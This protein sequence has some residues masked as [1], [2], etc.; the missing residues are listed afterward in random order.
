MRVRWQPVDG[1][2]GYIVLYRSI[3]GTE[4]QLD[5]EVRVRADVSD[6]QLAQLLPN[7]AYSISV[8]AQ[9]GEAISQPMKSVGVTCKCTH[10]ALGN[11]IDCRWQK[12]ACGMCT[13]QRRYSGSEL[14]TGLA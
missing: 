11:L 12:V 7:T 9:Y 1:A 3:N 4:P 6:I 10:S 14:N 13:S 5:K 2:S 8:L